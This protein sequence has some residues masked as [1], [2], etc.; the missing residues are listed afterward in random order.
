MAPPSP[1]KIHP[2]ITKTGALSDLVGKTLP[3][4]SLTQLREKLITDHP[5]FGRIDVRPAPKAFDLRS[6]G[7]K[8]EVRDRVFTSPIV[9]FYMTNPIA[10]ASVAM[11]ECS[12]SRRGNVPAAA[13]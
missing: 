9:D 5:V 3:Y 7:Q 1:M 8:G 12:A 2:L 13:E 11:A 6:V 4:D 10:R